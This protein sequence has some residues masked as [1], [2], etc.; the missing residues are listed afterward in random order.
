MKAPLLYCIASWLP[1]ARRGLQTSLGATALDCDGASRGRSLADAARAKVPLP[2]SQGAERVFPSSGIRVN[3]GPRR[4]LM[5]LA[6]SQ[7]REGFCRLSRN[8]TLVE[9]A[10]QVFD[11][12]GFMSE[13]G[14]D[15]SG[16]IAQRMAGDASVTVDAL[17]REPP[18]QAVHALYYGIQ[19][20]MAP[21]MAAVG[22][23]RW[24]SPW[25]NPHVPGRQI[26][27]RWIAADWPSRYRNPAVIDAI[28]QGG[29]GAA[30][31]RRIYEGLQRDGYLP[32][33][34]FEGGLDIERIAQ[35]AIRS[36]GTRKSGDPGRRPGALRELLAPM[37]NSRA[38]R[39]ALDA[40]LGTDEQPHACAFGWKATAI[41]ATMTDQAL[42][43]AAWHHDQAGRRLKIFLYLHDVHNQTGRATQIAR[44]THNMHWF[45]SSRLHDT[46]YDDEW[47]A[48]NHEIVSAGGPK[49]GGFIFDSNALHRARGAGSTARY[50]VIIEIDRPFR[51]EA[52]AEGVGGISKARTTTPTGEH[53]P[54][55][56]P[57]PTHFQAMCPSIF[58]A[59]VAASWNIK[60]CPPGGRVLPVPGKPDY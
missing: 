26:S 11:A 44:R 14:M 23:Q 40:Y 13:A 36:L 57:G 5:A 9:L 22:G 32:I 15:V 46:R 53:A 21:I 49:G 24:M 35:I 28:F 45:S 48:R 16:W 58:Q 34:R 55:G 30:E 39:L 54:A 12:G 25:S 43:T 18:L 56:M 7:Y 33:Q 8:D 3:G 6:Y 2:Y 20:P 17:L 52:V 31:G 50:V 47:V 10:A 29:E 37:F 42:G 1:E 59:P 27:E 19:G 60:Q 38:L 41:Q 51:S 4:Q